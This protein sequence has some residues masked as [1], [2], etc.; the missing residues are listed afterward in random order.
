MHSH[1]VGL[2]DRENPTFQSIHDPV[3]CFVS[4]VAIQ[5]SGSKENSVVFHTSHQEYQ[6][7]PSGLADTAST[8]MWLLQVADYI[9]KDLLKRST[10]R[11][12]SA[13]ML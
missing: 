1:I 4:L 13:A 8:F 3:K 12:L 10:G 7:A 5:G 9:R 2:D 11:H 6:G